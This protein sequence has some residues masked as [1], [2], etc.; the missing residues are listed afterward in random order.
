MALEHNSLSPNS[1]SQENFPIAD[2]T[3]TT[4][5][6][7]LEMLFVLMFDQYFNG[8][9]QVVSK[10]SVV[11]TVD[12]S[13]KRQQQNIIPSTSITVDADLTHLDIQTTPEPTTQASTVIA[14]KNIN[15]VENAQVDEDEFI[16][17]FSTPSTDH[18]AKNVIN[19]KWLWK[20]KCDEE[21]TVIHNKHILWLRDIDMKKESTSKNH[22]HQ[23]LD[24]KQ[25]GYSLRMLH[26]KLFPVYQLDV[27]IAFLNGPLKQKVYV[28]QPDGF[29]DPHH[30]D[31]VYRLKKALSG[32]K[33]ALRAW[34]NELSKFLVS[35]GF[36]KGCLDTRKITF[37]GIQFLGG[38]KLVSWLSKKQDYTSLSTTE[39]EYVSLSAY[40]AHRKLG[41][42]GM[43]ER[44]TLDGSP[45]MSNSSPLIS[46]SITIHMP[47]GLYSIDVATTF[48][49]PLTTVGDLH[50]LIN[51]IEAGKYDELLSGMTNDDRMET[52][53]AIGNICKSIQADNNNDDVIPCKSTS[54]AGAAGASANDQPK[55]N[56]NFRTLVVDPIFDGVN[57]SIPRNVVEKVSTR[58][59]HTLYG[60]FIGKRM[61]FPVVEYYA[62]N[63]W[64]K[65][66]LKMIMM[67][68]KE[69]DLVDV[70]TIGIPSLSGVGFTK[71][72]IRVEYE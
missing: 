58:F 31:K 69:A 61:V 18:T 9:T 5:L 67:N 19:L 34:Y 4:S 42:K 50:K 60:Y 51:D 56:S 29:V 26:T 11:T 63:N 53:D 24:W 13:D 23:L 39:V 7:E 15:Q 70:V 44:V 10:S 27:K 22:L 62:R 8:A 68:S 17:T 1:Y 64:G 14:T 25:S 35:K 40:C 30:P 32:L 49:V 2:E 20:N 37:G 57:I 52:M 55:L 38:D 3:V 47:R 41:W 54:Y 28:N 65:H 12:A 43:T 21:Y 71:E 59:E 66:G 6:Q 36:S 33:Q 16:N 72:T 45:M 48:E 46:P